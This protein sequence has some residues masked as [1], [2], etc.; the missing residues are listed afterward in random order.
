MCESEEKSA[1]HILLYYGLVSALCYF[2]SF[3]FLWFLLNRE[4]EV[5]QGGTTALLK[6]KIV[7]SLEND[8]LL[9]IFDYK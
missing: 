7:V 5:Y 8:P 9:L 4:K 1:N 3:S 6:K 2:F